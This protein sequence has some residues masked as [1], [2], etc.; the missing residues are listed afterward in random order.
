MTSKADDPGA[1]EVSETVEVTESGTEVGE[2]VNVGKT[3]EETLK[4][5]IKD[6]ADMKNQLM[7]VQSES[8]KTEREL[9]MEIEQIKSDKYIIESE[10]EDFKRNVKNTQKDTEKDERNDE[11]KGYDFKNGP[12]P[13]QYDYNDKDY[14]GWSD[15]LMAMM[16][17]YDTKWEKILKKIEEYGKKPIDD[18]EMKQIGI[19]LG[20]NEENMNK[21]TK[22][23]YTTLIQYTKGD[24]KTKVTTGGMGASMDSYRHIA[25]KGK[26]ATIQAQMHRRIK[27]MNPDAAKNISEVEAKINTWKNDMRLLAEARQAQDVAMLCVGCC[28][29][30]VFLAACSALI[31]VC[32]VCWLLIVVCCVCG[33]SLLLLLLLLLLVVA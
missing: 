3:P 24:A 2:A 27:V 33:V 23:L 10:F 1:T 12:K 25:H 28:L 8:M 15:L 21:G 19:E 16:T 7:K 5:I 9:K 32:C 14:N 4:E 13:N 6:I 29:M 20:I 26:N 31:V 17:S 30:C 11:L 18:N 22:I